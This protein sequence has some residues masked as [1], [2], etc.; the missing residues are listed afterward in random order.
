MGETIYIILMLVFLLATS[1]GFGDIFGR[2][3]EDSQKRELIAK[4]RENIDM[5]KEEVRIFRDDNTAIRE[6][7]Q[8]KFNELHLLKER[9]KK[10]V[11]L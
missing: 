10:A 2:M 5:L 8:K 9:I 1:F 6:M 11:D 4:L 7:Y 3:Q